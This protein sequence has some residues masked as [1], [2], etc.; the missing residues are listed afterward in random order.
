MKKILLEL[1]AILLPYTLE[2][3]FTKIKSVINSYRYKRAFKQCDSIYLA[4]Y[5]TFRLVGGKRISIGKNVNFRLPLRIEAIEESMGQSYT[6][7]LVFKDGVKVDSYAHIACLNSIIIGENVSIGER[8]FI[9]DH[10]HGEINEE[11]IKLHTYT[12]KLYSK[13]GIQ[14]GDNVQI[15]EGCVILP[16]VHIGCNSIVGA[17][18]VVTKDIPPYS[19]AVGN[20]AKTIKTYETNII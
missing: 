18:S 11:T 7:N 10:M 3:Y 9:T 8:C 4:S 12:R 6:P 1:I 13:G 20:P 16:N 14:I 15:G 19:V 2:A 5:G 17:N